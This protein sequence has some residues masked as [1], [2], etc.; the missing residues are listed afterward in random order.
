MPYGTLILID[1]L[2]FLV[3]AWAWVEFEKAPTCLECSGKMRHRADCR[4][5]R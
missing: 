5:Q 4:T 3:F 2:A 1:V